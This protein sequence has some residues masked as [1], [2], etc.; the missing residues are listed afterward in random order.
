M[1]VGRKGSRKSERAVRGKKGEGKV[2]VGMRKRKHVP[3]FGLR[4][5]LGF[6]FPP[7]GVVSTTFGDSS[8]ESSPIPNAEN[9]FDMEAMARLRLWSRE[10]KEPWFFG[11]SRFDTD[12]APLGYPL[13]RLFFLAWVTLQ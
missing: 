5:F 11:A 10:E 1:V 3:C 2:L 8:S 13:E 7:E 4:V 12:S 6:E 9:A